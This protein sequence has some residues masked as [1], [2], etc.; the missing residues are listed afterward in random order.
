MLGEGLEISWEYG[1]EFVQIDTSNVTNETAVHGTFEKWI[2]EGKIVTYVTTST[3]TRQGDDVELRLHYRKEAQTDESV[4]KEVKTWGTSVITW[5]HSERQGI[6]QW[7]DN[8]H[9]RRIGPFRV[10]VLYRGN[11]GGRKV[12]LVSRAARPKQD[13]LREFL[14]G[15]DR[16]CVLSGEEQ[17]E[18]L[19]AA[20]IRGVDVGGDEFVDNA[21]LLRSDLHLL[22]DRRVLRFDV[23]N[24]SATVLLAPNVSQAYQELTGRSLPDSTFRRVKRALFDVHGPMVAQ[25]KKGK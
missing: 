12:Q 24:D 17:P 16:R 23:G 14:L 20:H 25:H 6:A 7:Y 11:S 13:P 21:I 10:K 19:Q 3:V 15:L 1:T 2:V 4:K 8:A 22:L 9:Q 18:V 5:R